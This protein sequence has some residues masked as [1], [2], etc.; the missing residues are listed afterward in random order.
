MHSAQAH[1]LT[2]TKEKEKRTVN[3]DWFVVKAPDGVYLY[4]EVKQE[5]RGRVKK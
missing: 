5:T 1:N 4:R 3:T 2:L